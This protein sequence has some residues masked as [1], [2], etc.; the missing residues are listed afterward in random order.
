VDFA[1]RLRIK[2]REIRDN[3]MFTDVRVPESDFV[4]G[5]NAEEAVT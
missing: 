1:L 4:V 5:G 2:N 3:P